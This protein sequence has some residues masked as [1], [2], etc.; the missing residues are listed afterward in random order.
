LNEGVCAHSGEGD[1]VIGRP[2]IWKAGTWTA[3]HVIAVLRILRPAR[4]E[5]DLLTMKE[6][7][8]ACSNKVR[9]QTVLCIEKRQS[10]WG[11]KA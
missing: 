7:P 10:Q 9:S 3:P 8:F 1:Y 6:D 4:Y 11:Q 5:T 2:L